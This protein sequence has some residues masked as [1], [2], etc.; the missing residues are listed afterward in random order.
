[1]TGLSCS[2]CRSQLHVFL[3]DSFRCTSGNKFCEQFDLRLIEL[4]HAQHRR[5]LTLQQFKDMTVQIQKN[6]H[7]LLLRARH[8]QLDFPQTDAAFVDCVTSLHANLYH[9]TGLSFAG[10]IR[11]EEVECG[12]LAY[13]FSGEQPDQIV[14]KLKQLWREVLAE[15]QMNSHHKPDFATV[16]A[17]F[18]H[19]YFRIHPFPDG[20]GRTGRIV[21]AMM[22]FNSHRWVFTAFPNQGKWRTRYRTALK[23]A[24]R[25]LGYKKVR[26]GD[27]HRSVNPYKYLRI[28]LEQ[29]LEPQ[30]RAEDLLEES[31]DYDESTLPPSPSLHQ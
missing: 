15:H 4:A 21:L 30:P 20:N 14:S 10:A 23:Y 29:H 12:H 8:G 19:T 17:R 27:F 2:R 7:N 11:S 9:A 28:W 3:S 1:M 31:P 24:D 5:A 22:A 18:L 13:K 26:E 16:C 6:H 25:H